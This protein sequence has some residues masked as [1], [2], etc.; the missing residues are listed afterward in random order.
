MYT[1]EGKKRRSNHFKLILKYVQET[2]KNLLQGF[3]P[4]IIKPSQNN[5][6]HRSKV[7]KLYDII[8]TNKILSMK[9]TNDIINDQSWFMVYEEIIKKG[10]KSNHDFGITHVIIN[11]KLC[12]GSWYYCSSKHAP[13]QVKKIDF[14]KK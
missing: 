7:C 1:H 14:E 12:V 8:V 9:I 4:F 6:L 13:N 2:R 10:L 3:R 5:K 11:S